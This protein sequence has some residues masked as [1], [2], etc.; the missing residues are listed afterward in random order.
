MFSLRKKLGVGL[1]KQGGPAVKPAAVA[2]EPDKKTTARDPKSKE[3]DQSKTDQEVTELD[4]TVEHLLN[5]PEAM[6]SDGMDVKAGVPRSEDAEMHKDEN[7]DEGEAVYSQNAVAFQ[8][9]DMMEDPML[10][11]DTGE[12]YYDDDEE[13]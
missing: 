11:S 4:N 8:G 3:E 1:I 10:E 6:T 5:I 2:S 13:C 12:D 9:E 7:D